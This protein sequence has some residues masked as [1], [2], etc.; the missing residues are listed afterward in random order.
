MYIIKISKFITFV[1]IGLAFFSC[2]KQEVEPQPT[3]FIVSTV[4]LG[5]KLQNPY[6]LKN[7]QTALNNLANKNRATTTTLS[8]S[9][10]YVR[11]M[12]QNQDDLS[13]LKI[14]STL[15]LYSYPLDYE[16]LEDVDPYQDFN[17]T[18]GQYPYQYA[19]VKVDYNFPNVE[20]EILEE[21]YIP[22]ELEEGRQQPIVSTDDLVTEALKITNNLDKEDEET[23]GKWRPAGTIKVWDDYF[24][25]YVPVKHLEVRA[26]R[27]FTTHKGFTNANGYYACD[28]KFRRKANYSLKFERYHFE[29]LVS[30]ATTAELNGPKKKGD[31]NVNMRYGPFKFFATIFR[32][33]SHYYYDNIHG[34]RRPPQNNFWHTQ[35]KIG[36]FFKDNGNVNGNCAP[37]RQFLNM[38]SII[39]IYNPQ[40]PSYKIY[41]TTYS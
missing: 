40:N 15:I 6:S 30:G 38:G 12:P 10:Y 37:I 16:I 21:L 33:T 2:K 24:E 34:L 19:A 20:Y 28:G 22:E 11:F 23:K 39:H 35:L 25:T 13:L 27:W 3:S 31:W 7:M 8:A 14:D 4:K 32:A 36:A 17:L 18:E 9:H 26:R 5:K 29:I 1:L 41:G